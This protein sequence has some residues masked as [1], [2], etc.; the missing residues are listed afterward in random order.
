MTA[1][2]LSILVIAINTY[3]VVQTV[4]DFEFGWAALLLV[5]V[6]GICYLVFCVYL[7]VHMAVSMGNRNLLR[8]DF[9][10]KYIMGS[11]E[12]QLAVNPIS[13]SR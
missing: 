2:L 4:N 11:I 7:V 5:I 1:I 10:S 8:Y 6:I 12:S 9:V 3:F 13:Y